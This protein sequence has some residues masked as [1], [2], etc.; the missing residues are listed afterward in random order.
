MTTSYRSRPVTQAII[1]A[2]T[3]AALVVGDGEKPDTGG[4][5]GTPEQTPFIPYVVV[6]PLGSY[7]FDGTINDP[8]ADVWPLH[9]ITAY[10]ATRAQCE[11]T[12][13]NVRAVMLDGVL[14]VAD[15][16]VCIVQPDLL[17]I[18]SR[19]DDVQPPLYM[20]PDRYEICTTPR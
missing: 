2:L 3:N 16:A 18:V 7:E 20:A 4:W 19:V 11:E 12:A 10:G 6:H 5:S 8:Y 9:Q 14:I 1:T 13:D 17:G 15:R